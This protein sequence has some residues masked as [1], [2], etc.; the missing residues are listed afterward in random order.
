MG[1]ADP[2]ADGIVVE[3]R[4]LD[5]MLAHLDEGSRKT[6]D[7]PDECLNCQRDPSNRAVKREVVDSGTRNHAGK[8]TGWR[9]AYRTRRIC[10]DCG[11]V[12]NE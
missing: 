9:R 12:Y 5:V 2:A 3:D 6:S 4:D 11:R 7:E 1:K 10:P 8:Q